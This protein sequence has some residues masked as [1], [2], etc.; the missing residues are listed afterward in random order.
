[1][2]NPRN[3]FGV[4]GPRQKPF[5]EALRA[6]IAEAQDDNDYRSLRRIA[7][8]LL[9]LAS[10]GDVRAIQEVSDRLDGKAPQFQT[11]DA[12]EFRRALE[13]SDD[14]LGHIARSGLAAGAPDSVPSDS[15][16]H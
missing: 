12:D 13:M 2:E 14:E 4:Q 10:G 15:T 5:R 7:R 16:K 3:K 11:G 8:R 1:M 6:E 9:Q